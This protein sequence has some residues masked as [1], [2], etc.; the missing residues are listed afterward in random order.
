VPA[1]L[2]PAAPGTAGALPAVAPPSAPDRRAPASAPAT[3][4]S[5]APSPADAGPVPA[6]A[7][8]REPA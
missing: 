7:V 6:D 4:P 8:R 2:Q 1:P 5:G 3:P